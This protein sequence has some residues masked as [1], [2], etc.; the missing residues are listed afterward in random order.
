[1]Y[2]SA[3]TSRRPV[4]ISWQP[5]APPKPLPEAMTHLYCSCEAHPRHVLLKE[6]PP[7]VVNKRGRWVGAGAG[8][9]VIGWV[10]GEGYTRKRKYG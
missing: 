6:E 4:G 3:A 5:P 8:A 10:G 7:A 9:W 1:M 2:I